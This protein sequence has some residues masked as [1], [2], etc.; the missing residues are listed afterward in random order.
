[1]P[2]FWT[3]T[4]ELMW[5]EHAQNHGVNKKAYPSLKFCDGINFK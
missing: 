5:S 2:H 4:I 1:M 3:C